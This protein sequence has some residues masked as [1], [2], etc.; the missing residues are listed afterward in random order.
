MPSS[1]PSSAPSSEEGGDFESIPVRRRAEA[2]P[3]EG[4]EEESFFCSATDFA[5]DGG[6]NHVHICHYTS[7]IGYRTYCIP[8]SDSEIVRFYA[9]DYCGPCVGG[10]DEDRAKV[11]AESF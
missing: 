9:S 3:T 4:M 11:T 6:P 1:A 7:R 8:E 10:F 2:E 5:C